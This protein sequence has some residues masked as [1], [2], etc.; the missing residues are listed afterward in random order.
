MLNENICV[1]ICV[2]VYLN[3]TIPD[4][5]IKLKKFQFI[6]FL[7]LVIIHRNPKY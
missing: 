5:L 1:Y 7:F 2:H 3:I 4:V 6:L